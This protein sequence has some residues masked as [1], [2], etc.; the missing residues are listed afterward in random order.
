[1]AK[2]ACA[3]VA[4]ACAHVAAACA[5]AAAA[6]ALAAGTALAQGDRL[7]ELYVKH[8]GSKPNISG[9]V[10]YA[11]GQW[12]VSGLE[13]APGESVD[14][15]V[16]SLE[17]D[18]IFTGGNGPFDYRFRWRMRGQDRPNAIGDSGTFESGRFQTLRG[19]VRWQ[20]SENIKFRIG[21]LAVT[22]VTSTTEVDPIQN[23][24]CACYT[25]DLAD[26]GAMDFQWSLGDHMV[27]IA[28]SGETTSAMSTNG[29]A[30]RSIGRPRDVGGTPGAAGNMANS[31]NRS[32]TVFA[33]FA[34]G[35]LVLA[36]KAVMAEGEN[37]LRDAAGTVVVPP[38]EGDRVNDFTG[39]AVGT[40]A[41][42]II[43]LG[44]AKLNLDL[45]HNSSD[46]AQGATQTITYNGISFNWG[47]LHLGAG[48]GSAQLEFPGAPTAETTQSNLSGHY[49][50]PVGVGGWAGPELQLQ[51]IAQDDGAGTATVDEQITSIRW[52][53]LISF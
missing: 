1:M 11:F 33:R 28:V 45:E 39:K 32:V 4:A 13:N 21:K 44:T 8:G 29:S 48:T 35:G 43:S 7:N 24:P 50:I 49:R 2:A 47:E 22:P 17:A 42:L 37:D 52:L 36:A 25:G 10:G 19:H 14:G 9:R 53:M 18:M 38:A 34:V 30:V 5:L 20:I 31:G 27:G 41:H 12:E 15:L 26:K 51:T 23:L 46:L 3:H 16:T 40:S 6:C